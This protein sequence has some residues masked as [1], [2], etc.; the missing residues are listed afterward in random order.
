M[1]ITYHQH[2]RGKKLSKGSATVETLIFLIV[3]VTLILATVIEVVVPLI[4]QHEARY[5]KALSAP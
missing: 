2:C 5:M 4:E 3:F 1:T